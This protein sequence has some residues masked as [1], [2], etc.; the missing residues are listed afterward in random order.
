MEQAIAQG[1]QPAKLK[2]APAYRFLVFVIM[3]V[4]WAQIFIG[5]QTVATYGTTIMSDLNINNATLS[6]ISSGITV[7]MGIMCMVSGMVGAKIG[8]KRTIVLGCII[9]AIGGLLYFTNPTNV[10]FLI[11]IRLIQGV[12]GG[13]IQA[14]TVSLIVAWFPLRE[15]SMASGLQLGLYGVA[16]STTVLFCNFFNSMGMTWAQGCGTFVTVASLIGAV[17]VGFL[18]QDVE[19]KYG[20]SVIDDAIEGGSSAGAS[21]A[22]EEKKDESKL[23]SLKR[24]SNYRE[25][26]KSPVFW[27]LFFIVVGLSGTSYDLSYLYPFVFP[28]FGYSTDQVTMIL[29]ISMMGTV[30]TGLLGGIISDR[31]FHGRRAETLLISFAFSAI[32]IVIFIALGGSH[33]TAAVITVVAFIVYA[34]SFLAR[35]PMWALPAQVI[36][37]SFFVRGNGVLLLIS[38]LSGMLFMFVSGALADLTGSYVPGLIFCVVF[39]VVSAILSF[40][41]IKKYRC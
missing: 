14:Y 32:G 29:S 36:E 26:F 6:L 4:T 3:V 9:E 40:V 7:A 17:L 31:L 16:V 8:G 22:S 37:P 39:S 41:L 15:R 18:Y 10:V 35:G 34:A 30:I 5:M 38:N 33:V 2:K 23:A 20:V 27:I 21:A 25:L 1:A 19:K 24:P 13:L 12:G 11:V 28:E